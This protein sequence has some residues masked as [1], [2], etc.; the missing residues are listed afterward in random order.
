MG[1]VQGWF[2]FD[3]NIILQI[4]VFG[5]QCF[6][7]KKMT[8]TTKTKQKLLMKPLKDFSLADLNY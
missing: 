2:S 6:Q 7:K 4:S 3:K 8:T 1:V 5:F